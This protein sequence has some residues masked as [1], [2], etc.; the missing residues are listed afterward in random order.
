MSGFELTTQCTGPLDIPI[1][2]YKSR[3][4]GI[5]VIT[6]NVEKI[7]SGLVNGY[8]TLATESDCDDGCPHTLEHIV[9]MGSDS[10]PYKVFV[11]RRP[12][13]KTC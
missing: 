7:S 2:V 1:R 12:E 6:A 8:F 5:R 10:Y 11:Y 13:G 4:T 9:F 3:R